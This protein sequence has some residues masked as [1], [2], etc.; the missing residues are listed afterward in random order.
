MGCLSSHTMERKLSLTKSDF[1]H[2]KHG[3]VRTYY[4]TLDTLGDGGYGVV[5]RIRERKSGLIRAMKEVQK[6]MISDEQ[7]HLILNE[8]EILIR[9]DHPNIMKIYEVLETPKSYQI[10]C[11][12]LSGGEL[13]DVLLRQ[14]NFSEE[15][16]A[17]YIYDI[18][19]GVYY[20]HNM[21]IVHNDLKLENLML[22]SKDPDA[23]VKI[24]DFG[25]SQYFDKSGLTGQLGSVIPR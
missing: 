10:I 4:E 24:I 23:R 11:E 19:S 7:H 14:K 12:Y 9:L 16:S 22:D 5:T 2:K 15:K 6:S 3:S 18:L 17:K 8:I 21:N 13:L 1:V 25:I 20:C